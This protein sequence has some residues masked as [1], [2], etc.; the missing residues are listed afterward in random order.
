MRFLINNGINPIHV[1]QHNKTKR[2]YWV[3][4]MDDVLSELLKKW[5]NKGKENE[6]LIAI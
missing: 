4:K 5:T 1:G 3:F 6:R 2:M